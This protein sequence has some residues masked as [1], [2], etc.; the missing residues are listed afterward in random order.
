MDDGK[1]QGFSKCVS[2]VS[3]YVSEH[4]NERITVREIARELKLN[5]AISTLASKSRRATAFRRS[6]SNARLKRLRK[7]LK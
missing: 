4:I 7:C 1:K 6:Y 2:R 5:Q 3:E